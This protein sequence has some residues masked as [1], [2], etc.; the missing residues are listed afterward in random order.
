[1]Q[2]S[3]LL[4][5][6]TKY[7][8]GGIESAYWNIS[9]N[10]VTVKF[11][12]VDRSMLGT[13]KIKNFKGEDFKNSVLGIYTSSEL[14]KLLKVFGEDD[15]DINLSLVKAGDNAVAI[16]LA[17]KFIKENFAL[18]DMAV[19]PKIPDLKKMP[20][21]WQVHVK[22][23]DKMADA[24]IK[25]KQALPHVKTFA[26]DCTDSQATFILGQTDVNTNNVSIDVET[27]KIEKIPRVH[28]SADVLSGILSCNK[29]L[30]S[31][32]KVSKESAAKIE[33][34]T[35]NY[36]VMYFFATKKPV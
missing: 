26:V 9:D 5:V 8:F 11:I 20:D 23:T 33:F 12:A 17:N 36:S 19:M 13:L 25:A 29:G 18:S 35:E 24:F 28:F 16:R 10:S 4:N 14:S 30:E 22:V 31:T 3:M 21:E 2:T 15:C 34:E 1:M 32:F 27:T 6:L 7:N